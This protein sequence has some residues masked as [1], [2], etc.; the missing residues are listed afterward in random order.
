MVAQE[1]PST[2][3]PPRGEKC[4]EEFDIILEGVK[5]VYEEERVLFSCPEGKTGYIYVDDQLEDR[6]K[7]NGYVWIKCDKNSG[8]WRWIG[9]NTKLTKIKCV[10]K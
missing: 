2:E 4:P 7:F 10:E 3:P 5:R 1:N 9:T 6:K 8:N